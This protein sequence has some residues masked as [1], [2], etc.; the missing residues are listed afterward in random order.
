[1]HLCT[2]CFNYYSG[3]HLLLS[4]QLYI[5]SLHCIFWFHN[6]CSLTVMWPHQRG[7][8]EIPQD[9]SS[10]SEDEEFWVMAAPLL[11][12][13]SI[14]QAPPNLTDF[15]ID[16]SELMTKPKTIIESPGVDC[17]DG[18]LFEQYTQ[19]SHK[20]P[21]PSS[22]FGSEIDPTP[23]T[24]LLDSYSVM[25]QTLFLTILSQSMACFFNK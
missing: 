11:T 7:T 8:L 23:S 4:L 5:L 22:R 15:S 1:M 2:W 24:S 16:L 10:D 9:P 14:T 21:N 18:H 20:P 6:S 13:G 12:T 3:S 25:H 17:G 19:S